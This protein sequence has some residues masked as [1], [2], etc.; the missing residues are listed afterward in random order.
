LILSRC[1]RTFV[2]DRKFNAFKDAMIRDGVRFLGLDKKELALSVTIRAEQKEKLYN[3]VGK[4]FS[5][6]KAG[7]AKTEGD[8]L[9]VEFLLSEKELSNIKDNAVNQAV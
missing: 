1:C 5:D 9:V 3:I 7:A 2:V 8:N 4:E 6:F